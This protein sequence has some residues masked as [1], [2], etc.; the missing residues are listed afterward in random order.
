MNIVFAN[1]GEAISR[2]AKEIAT[3]ARLQLASSQ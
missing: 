2:H 1:E 3:S